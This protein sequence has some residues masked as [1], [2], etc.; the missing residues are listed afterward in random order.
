MAQR[1]KEIVVSS[2]G[3]GLGAAVAT[4][5]GAQL[6]EVEEVRARGYWE[7]VWRRFRRDRIAIGSGVFIIFLILVAF[8]GAP[9]AKHYIGHGPDDIFTGTAAVDATSQLPANPGTRI[10][11][12]Y[13]NHHDILLL[14]ASNRLGQDEFLRILYGARVSLEVAGLST[15]GLMIIGVVLGAIAGYFR[16]WID[17]IISRVTEITMAFPLILFIVSMA[18]TLGPRLDNITLG[19]F[20]RGVITLVLIFSIFGWYYPARI[21]RAQVLSI[22][23]KEYVEAARMIGA[24]DARIIRSHIL[25]HLVAPII[26]YSTLIIATYVLFEA[27]LSFLGIGIK[28]PT[29]SWGNL[30]ADAPQFYTTRPLLMLWPGLAVLLTTLAFN[31]LGDGLRDAFDPRSSQH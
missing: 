18:A 21:M 2:G 7:L 6:G 5:T 23:E 27:G 29:A 25:P 8:V 11:N 10:D 31:L 28:P 1:E 20:P 26:V 22:R 4:E 15:L 14:G 12:Y 19:I 16:G 13:T 30:L 24:S 17:T 9:I 3:A